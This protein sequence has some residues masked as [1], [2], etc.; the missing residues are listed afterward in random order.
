M[1]LKI[2]P[3]HLILA[4]AGWAFALSAAAQYQWVGKDGRKV[5]SDR[6]P[7]ADIQE[8]DIIR[9]PGGRRVALPVIPAETTETDSTTAAA[10]PAP[11]AAKPKVDP[12]A[13]KISGK[14]AELEARKKKL[15]EEAATKKKA[16]DEKFA[17]AQAENC[18]RA[19]KA[20]ATFQSGVRIASTNAKGEREIMDDNAKAAEIKRMQ[21]VVDR[22]CNKLPVQ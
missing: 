15:A 3:K 10:A 7:P 11:V 4:L 22:D 17:L 14:D 21:I 6:P 9:Q 5:F 12:N 1:D 13:P 20:V 2:T 16:E 18:E 19:K 8:K